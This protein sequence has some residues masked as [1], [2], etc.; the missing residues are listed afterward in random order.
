MAGADYQWFMLSFLFF[1]GGKGV[2]VGCVRV[3]AGGVCLLWVA[4]RVGV[5]G[6]VGVVGLFEADAA[7]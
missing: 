6:G 1:G 3:C 4:V 7:A 5:V 2:R